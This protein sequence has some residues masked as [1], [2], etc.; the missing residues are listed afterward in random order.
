MKKRKMI[1]Q[2]YQKNKI[3]VDADYIDNIMKDE[4]RVITF[5]EL[6]EKEK[7]Y[8]MNYILG[9]PFN[10]TNFTEFELE[11]MSKIDLFNPKMVEVIKLIWQNKDDELKLNKFLCYLNN[12]TNYKVLLHFYYMCKLFLFS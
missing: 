10:N 4:S 2:I 12:K 6:Y 11:S 5:M 7:I 1:E 8:S 9:K 3:I